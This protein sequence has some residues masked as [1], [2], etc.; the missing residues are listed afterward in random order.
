MLINS[1]LYR[2]YYGV[3]VFSL[4]LVLWGCNKDDDTVQDTVQPTITLSSPTQEQFDAGFEVGSTVTVTG[5]ITDND[6][7]DRVSLVLSTAAGIPLFSEEWEDINQQSLSIN[8]TVTIPAI[9]PAG[10]YALTITAVDRSNNEASVTHNFAIIVPQVVVNVTTPA[11][12]PDNANVHIVGAFNDWDP[13]QT[14]YR[15]TKVDDNLYRIALDWTA[16]TEYKFTLGSW[17]RVEKG[18]ECEEVDNR[19]FTASENPQTIDVTIANWRGLG[20]CPDE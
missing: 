20:E 18:A 1:L 12:T 7:L 3:L 19:I 16:G 6:M 4:S 14:T 11:T 17:E 15:L 5:T 8:E 13:G 10:Q 9:T 2:K